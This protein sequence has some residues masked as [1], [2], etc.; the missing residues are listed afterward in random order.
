MAEVFAA[1]LVGPAGFEKDVAVKRLLPR[2]SSDPVFLERFLNEARLAA[3]LSHPNIVQIFELGHDGNDHY[4]VM[5]AVRGCSLRMLLGRLAEKKGHVPA[6]IAAYIGTA[7]C[8]GLAHAHDQHRVIHRDVSPHNVL[9]S[10]DGAV[11]L[12]DFGIARARS[13]ERLTQVG[14]VIGKRRY[15]SPE[16]MAGE[17]LDGRSDLFPA[18]IIL[19]E[20]LAGVHPFDEGGFDDTDVSDRIRSGDRT[21]VG[22]AAPGVDKALCDVVERSLEIHRDRR[23]AT[24]RDMGKALGGLKTGSATDLEELLRALFGDEVDR[25]WPVD[26]VR[27]DGADH[28]ATGNVAGGAGGQSVHEITISSDIGGVDE[29]DA[30]TDPARP[31]L[32]RITA[33]ESPDVTEPDGSAPQQRTRRTMLA[34]G[35][36]VGALAAIGV[37]AVFLRNRTPEG[38]AGVPARP[39]QPS[40]AGEIAIVDAGEAAV[41]DAGEAIAFDED[42]GFGDAGSRGA[43]KLVRRKKGKL[44]VETRPWTNVRVDGKRAGSTP[45]AIELTVGRHRVTMENDESGI[46]REVDVVISSDEPTVLR[47]DLRK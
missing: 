8:A 40:D 32:A 30:V 10:F 46:R 28:T 34:A 25:P 22:E 12:I 47:L 17:P 1:Q 11:K 33:E 23:F 39:V 37:G 7:L 4:I 31:M 27:S 43:P 42:E 35:L 9:L 45:L 2:F 21:P 20:M 6:P 29:M 18:G 26:D 38:R 41:V 19:Y 24:A 44:T 14:Q 15:M 5:E 36:G 16:Q 13:D 3:R